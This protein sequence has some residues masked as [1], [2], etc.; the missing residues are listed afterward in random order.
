MLN[1]STEQSHALVPEQLRKLVIIH[2]EF[3]TDLLSG[4]VLL[5]GYT[6]QRAAGSYP[7]FHISVKLERTH[8][9]QYS[10]L[11]LDCLLHS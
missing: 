8:D 5:E 9:N 1:R 3:H 7:H 11:T 4:S 10:A 2:T 6:I